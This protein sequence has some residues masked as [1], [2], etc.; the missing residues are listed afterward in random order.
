VSAPDTGGLDARA[1]AQA[2]REALRRRI[3]R[4]RRTVIAVAAALFIAAFATLY[5]QLSSGRDPAL[6]ASRVTTTASA[7]A[8]TSSPGSDD[9]GTA[10]SS[11]DSGTDQSFDDSGSSSS[12]GS[13][14]ADQP[15]AVTTQQ[16]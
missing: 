13:S 14:T 12:S 7:P 15:S 5:V 6:S 9:S 10:Q 2:R 8:S 3:G 1:L 16:S 11:D 4:I